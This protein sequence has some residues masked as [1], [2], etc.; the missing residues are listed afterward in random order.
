ML[1]AESPL[2]LIED[3]DVLS[4]SINFEEDLKMLRI[5]ILDALN[6]AE[7]KAIA[8]DNHGNV[9]KIDVVI[10]EGQKSPQTTIENRSNGKSLSQLLEQLKILAHEHV[11]RSKW[12]LFDTAIESIAA[13]IFGPSGSCPDDRKAES[14][15]PSLYSYTRQGTFDLELQVSSYITI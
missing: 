15:I 10:Q 8:E 6:N 1:A 12:H 11:E 4:T 9:N 2:K 5:P 14:T 3:D 7:S 13:V